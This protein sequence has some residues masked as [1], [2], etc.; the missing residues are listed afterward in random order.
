[1]IILGQM[2]LSLLPAALIVGSIT[3]ATALTVLA[4]RQ[5]PKPG[6]TAF[7]ALMAAGTAWVASSSVG[8]FTLDRTLRVLLHTLRWPAVVV[9]PVA[10][11]V[12]ALEY[13]S[14]DEYVTRKTMAL[15]SVV[16]VATLLL[17][18][19]N[20][21]HELVYTSRTVSV[22]D[23]ISIVTVTYGPWFWVVTAFMYTLLGV[24]TLLILQ[25]VVGSRS[26]YRGQAAALL[27]TV[28]APWVGNIVFLTGNSPVR[29]FDP[30]P[31][32]F[33]ISG[34]AGIAALTQFDLLD[35]T[36]VSSRIAREQVIE[37]MDDGVVVVDTDGLIVDINPRAAAV[38]DC[39]RAAAVES[40]AS[41]LVPGYERLRGSDA[42]CETV[43]L[44]QGDGTR[45]YEVS[46]TPL[47]DSHD[48]ET[49]R[50]VTLHEVTERR[51]RV[52]Q[53]DVLNRVL[54]HN[55]RNQMNVVYGYA[56][57]LDGDNADIADRIQSKAMR[58]VN[59]GDKAREI[60]R[61]LT[62]D[63]E[64]RS[65]I[66]LVELVEIE[67][68]RAREA[69]P[70][71]DIEWSPPDRTVEVNRTLGPVLR[72]VLEN[73]AEHNDSDQ[74]E[75]GVSISVESDTITTRVTDNGPGIPEV[76]QSVL[77]REEETPLEHSSGLGLWLVNWGV[78]TM[79]GAITVDCEDGG[80]TVTITVPTGGVPEPV[81][82]E[83][84]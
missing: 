61:I 3:A 15:L 25:L 73:A 13:T 26:L 51:N 75:V 54:R 83:A 80:T 40:V 44:E 60:D 81:A 16:P 52:Q 77:R 6:A 66:D 36:P 47:E 69:Y 4:W 29:S 84:E 35:S 7:A 20:Q 41:D 38:L 49:G 23:T 46:A 48:R 28:L 39:E 56:S 63:D 10:W 59:L 14:R 45:Y 19:T 72:N 79:G 62:T 74:P 11:L 68:E 55:L 12:F 21:F 53:L 37:S 30:T 58:M 67:V 17:I 34:A 22:Y 8:L 64:Q 78:R 76:E 2:M 33:L 32:T 57:Q 50:I 42:D 43:E 24:G 5:R 27:I 70:G 82:P 71:V 18:G 9:V 1:M 65:P 31:F